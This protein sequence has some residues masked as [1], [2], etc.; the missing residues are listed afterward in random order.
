[1]NSIQS[2]KK[3]LKKRFKHPALTGS[4]GFADV[5]V[6]KDTMAKRGGQIAIKKLK[7]STEKEKTHNACEIFFL[8]ECIGMLPLPLLWHRVQLL[9][10]FFLK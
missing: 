9:L 4:G 5:F 1:M 2:I 6:S 7:N 10:F 8:G 3:S